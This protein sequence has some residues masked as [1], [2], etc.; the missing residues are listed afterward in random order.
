MSDNSIDVF[1]SCDEYQYNRPEFLCMAPLMREKPPGL[2]TEKLSAPRE[3]WRP[4]TLLSL[5]N[6]LY[7]DCLRKKCKREKKGYS[8]E[9]YCPFEQIL[10]R[11]GRNNF[12]KIKLFWKREANEYSSIYS[13]KSL[14]WPTH[15]IIFFHP[16]LKY[17]NLWEKS[18]KYYFCCILPCCSSPDWPGARSLT[19]TGI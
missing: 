2:K 4:G 15:M 1:I 14:K 8:V 7:T 5:M 16:V 12:F 10:L 6:I 19:K 18:K 9:N 17:I 13:N 3:K 11:I